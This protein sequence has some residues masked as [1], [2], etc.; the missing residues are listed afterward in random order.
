MIEFLEDVIAFSLKLDLVFLHHSLTKEWVFFAC[1]FNKNSKFCLKIVM[2]P[3][4]AETFENILAFSVK[5]DLVYSN[6]HLLKSGCSSV[7]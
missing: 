1:V 6:S 5:Q 7:F 2:F 3:W 4:V